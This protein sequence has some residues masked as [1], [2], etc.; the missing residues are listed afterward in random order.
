MVGGEL[1]IGDQV[2]SRLELPGVHPIF[3]LRTSFCF[4]FFHVSPG[5]RGKGYWDPSL[6]FVMGCGICVTWWAN[7]GAF[8]G[9]IL[10]T[11]RFPCI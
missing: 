8:R 9:R 5:N 11:G 2:G 4:P 10:R 1:Q 7:G 3:L 6:A